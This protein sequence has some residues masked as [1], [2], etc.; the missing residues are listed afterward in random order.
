[1]INYEKIKEKFKT[2][3]FVY[4]IDILKERTSYLKSK[5]N[6]YNLVYAVKANT[7]VIKEIDSGVERF[8]ICSEG[9]YDICNKLNI[10]H[11]KMVISGVNK[12]KNFSIK[13]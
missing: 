12:D 4:D 8:E 10:N 11:N 1:M 9:E 3:T 7:F 5:F 6:N 13:E 2:P